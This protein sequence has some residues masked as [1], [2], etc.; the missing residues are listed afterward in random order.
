MR[1]R[2]NWRG[3]PPPPRLS[4]DGNTLYFGANKGGLYAL[5]AADGK[6]RWQ[7]NVYGSIDPSPT[8]DKNGTLYSGSTIGHVFALEADS[9]RQI[10]DYDAGGT[11][12][13]ALRPLAQRHPGRRHPQGQS[14]GPG[15]PLSASHA[16][17]A[18]CRGREAGMLLPGRPYFR[19]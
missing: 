4:A 19:V 11:V 7:F 17:A 14:H 8:I 18:G 1:R 2:V 5:G 16:C 12:W 10:F 15:R 3:S 6:R 9:G 13:T